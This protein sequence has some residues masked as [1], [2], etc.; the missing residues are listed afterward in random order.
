MLRI[1]AVFGQAGEGRFLISGHWQ[2]EWSANWV[3]FFL[4][5]EGGAKQPDFDW[6]GSSIE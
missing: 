1:L 3:H 2:V 6:A 5:K 4:C